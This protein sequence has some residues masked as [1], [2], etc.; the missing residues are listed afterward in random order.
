MSSLN[1]NEDSSIKSTPHPFYL[2][3]PSSTTSSAITS[4]FSSPHHS[5]FESPSIKTRPT[6]KNLSLPIPKQSNLIK[7]TP[8]GNSPFL[9]SSPLLIPSTSSSPINSKG[10]LIISLLE[11]VDF[12]LLNEEYIKE[13]NDNG[14][15]PAIMS[16][17]QILV[18]SKEIGSLYEIK[19]RRTTWQYL[20][21]KKALN[22]GEKNDKYTFLTSAPFRFNEEFVINDVEKKSIIH[23]GLLIAKKKSNNTKEDNCND[24][25]DSENLCMED[26]VALTQINLNRFEEEVEVTQWYPFTDPYSGEGIRTAIKIR[27]SKIPLKFYIIFN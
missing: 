11:V 22:A 3:P 23:I 15:K 2:T 21:N 18:Q 19:E 1:I 14:S 24:K 6:S 5:K 7:S 26:C 4:F 16:S 8:I 12:P 10:S 9:P 17:I 27:V 13:N 25:E 20:N